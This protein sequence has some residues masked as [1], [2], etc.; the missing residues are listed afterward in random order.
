MHELPWPVRM[1]LRGIGAMNTGGRQLLSYLLFE[2]GY[3]RHLI[4]LGYRDAMANKEDL[5]AFM[6]GED[7]SCEGGISGWTSL[8]DEPI[9]GSYDK[10]GTGIGSGSGEED[11]P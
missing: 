3:T 10:P 11:H 2:S 8:D 1:L 4:D 9:Q 7:L 6:Q 5:L